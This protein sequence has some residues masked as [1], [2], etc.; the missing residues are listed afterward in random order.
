VLLD[1]IGASTLVA[2]SCR[3]THRTSLRDRTVPFPYRFHTV[4]R[5]RIMQH[6]YLLNF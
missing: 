2:V 6:W 3:F 4:S 1:A 5:S